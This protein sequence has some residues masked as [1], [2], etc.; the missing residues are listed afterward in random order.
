MI[1]PASPWFPHTFRG[2]FPSLVAY[3]L[4]H[5]NPEHAGGQQKVHPIALYPQQDLGEQSP[6]EDKSVSKLETK[7]SRA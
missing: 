3:P 6:V 1:S 2:L 5:P 4:S 7:D